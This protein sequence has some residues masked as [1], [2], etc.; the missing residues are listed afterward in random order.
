MKTQPLFK[1]HIPVEEALAEMR[2]VFESGFINEGE[3]VTQ[4]TTEMQK[5]FGENTC[6]LNSCTSALT[7]SLRL[8]GVESGDWV[9]ST[10]MTCVATNTPIV[11][12]GA[13]PIWAD[14]DPKT[15]C[16]DPASVEKLLSSRPKKHRYKAVMA[17]DWA[18]NPCDLQ[19]LEMI[20]AK[21]GIKLIQ[22][23]AH[24]MGATIDDKQVS[25]FA[26]YTCYSLQAIK[27]ITTGDGGILVCKDAKDFERAKQMKWFGINREHAKDAQ[28]NWKGQ[29]WDFDITEAGY[30]F[31]MNN[32]SA[33][34]GLAQLP[35]MNK[36]LSG[37]RGSA[38]VLN[39]AFANDEFI[40]PLMSYSGA[41]SAHWVYT[42]LVKDKRIDRDKL[43]ASLNDAGIKAG[44]VHVPN[45]HY[46]CF[47]DFYKDLPGVDDFSSRQ[48]SLPCGWWLDTEDLIHM[49]SATRTLCEEMVKVE[50]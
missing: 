45:H 24:A 27:H 26:D 43:V 25:E 31:N 37:H 39:V 12:A 17:V 34:I 4:L 40:Q 50:K 44:L 49:I 30:K 20:C 22:D 14:I 8:A 2:K 19:S 28:G 36:I 21:A 6:L 3:Q 41:K 13:F 29:H 7:L 42:V 47:K 35:H 46:T 5:V 9:I 33:A 32:V 18:G 48:F 1:V 10:P 38:E 11:T 23:A 16:I 15:G